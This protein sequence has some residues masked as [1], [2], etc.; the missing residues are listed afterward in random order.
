MK[1]FKLDEHGDIS[2]TDSQLDMVCGDELE[3]Q[4]MKTILRTNKGEW[5]FDREEGIDFK[6]ILGRHITGDLVKTQLQSGI[7]QV[8][9]D[10]T[11]EDFNYTVDR[12][13]RKSHISFTAR[14]ASDNA[15]FSVE[16]D[17]E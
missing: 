9:S 6:Q 15:M 5:I 16:N 13:N 10:Y 3:V 4:T 17:Y 7:N 2:F 14:R 8:N 12:Q 11:V 1:G